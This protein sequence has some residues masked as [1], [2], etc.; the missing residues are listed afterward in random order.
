MSMDL[1]VFFSKKYFELL[2]R[3]FYRLPF[4]FKKFLLSIFLNFFLLIKLNFIIVVLLNFFCFF[5]F[6]CF[7]VVCFVFFFK[8]SEVGLNFTEVLQ[9]SLH[10]S[11]MISLLNYFF[12]PLKR[13]C[14]F[15]AIRRQGS[16]KSFHI[17][18]NNNAL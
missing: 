13:V 6:L 16:F 18:I 14:Q 17:Q 12:L 9:R 7:S 3:F 8:F 11:M 4:L 2:F 10:F 1:W 5:R 15:W